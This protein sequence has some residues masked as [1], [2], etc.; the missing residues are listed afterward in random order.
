[1]QL[2][3]VALVLFGTKCCSRAGLM[4]AFVQTYFVNALL[5]FFLHFEQRLGRGVRDCTFH[6]TRGW[7]SSRT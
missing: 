1:M 2:K 3:S 4:T 5:E 6:F 7:N